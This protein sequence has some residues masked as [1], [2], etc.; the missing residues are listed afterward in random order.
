MDYVKGFSG[1]TLQRVSPGL[2]E[3]TLP[4]FMLPPIF[5]PPQEAVAEYPLSH[6]QRALWFLQRMAPES[7]A[8]N[9]VHAVRVRM[10]LDIPALRRAFQKLVDRHPVLRTTF[11][12]PHGEPV[13]RVHE[14]MEVS[15][16]VEDASTWS[17]EYLNA[18]LAEEVYRP[19]DLERGPLMRV[20]LFTRSPQDHILLLAMHHIVTDMWSMALIMYET[21]LLYQ[22]EITGV[23][24]PLKPLRFQYTDYVQWQEEMLAGPEG[25][26]LW[27]F[28]RKQLAG[29]LPVLNLPTDR[30]RPPIQTERGALQS[31]RLG[32]ELTQALKSLAKAHGATLYMTLLAAFQV[33]LHRYTGQED[34]LVGSPK[35]G[36]NRRV[37]RLVGYFINPVVLRADLSG[38]PTFSTFLKQVRQ[39]VLDAFEHDAYPFPLLVER[40]QPERDPSRPPI[41]QVVFA[42]QKTTRLVDGQGM[43]S[44]VLGLG[45]SKLELGGTPLEVVSL[46]QRVTPFDLTLLVT[47]AGRELGAAIEYNV[48]LFD[49]ATIRRMLGH[50]RT[51]LEGIVADPEQRVSDLPLLTEDERRQVLVEWNAT[52]ADYPQD[53]C[54]HELFEAQVERT[55]D[56]TAVVFED[57]QLTYRELNRRANQLA[58]YLRRLGVGPEVLVG[59][60]MERSLEMIIGLLGILKA[61]GAYLPLDPSYP[62]ERLA[63]ML[64]DAD[65]PILLT[66]THLLDRLG[67]KHNRQSAIGNRQFIICLDADWEAIAQESE[68]NPVSEVTPDNLAYVIYTSGSTGMPKGTLLEHRGLCNLIT[69]WIQDFNVGPGS[70][71]LQFFPV[72]FDGSVA[73]IFS[74]L[75]SGATLCVPRLETVVSMPDLHRLMQEQAVT[76]V[77]MTPSVLA[78]LPADGLPALENVLSGGESCTEKIAARWLSGRNFLNVYGPTEATVIASWYREG[79]SSWETA[80]VPIG[81]PI[82]NTRI[83][84]LDHHLQPV[85]VGVPGELYIGG[86][87]LARGYLN[88][89]E[90]TAERFIPDPFSGEPGAR[91]YKTGDLARYLPDGNIEFLGRTDHQVK[92][93]G[94]RVELGEIEAVLREH[95]A[96][97]EVVVVAREDVPGD[98]RLVAYVVPAQKPAPTTSEL[99][100]FLKERLPKYMIPSA[101]MVLDALPLTPN[102]KLDRRALP[103]PARVRPELERAFVAPRTPV[104]EELANIWAQLLGVER[105]GIYDNFFELGGHSLL[106]TQLLSRVRETFQV[107]VP[108]HS[109]FEAATVADLAV[110]IAQ[111]L[112]EQEDDA[113]M[114]Q[115]LAELEQLSED[116]VQ[117]M[118][119]IEMLGQ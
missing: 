40:L 100:R 59:I 42:W 54:A 84:L 90:L 47:E 61:G 80:T 57:G 58:H 9:V 101:F 51:L 5:T 28:W 68:D 50:L 30:P 76:H 46:E 23:P 74:T 114:A 65:V 106:V 24:A 10:E 43:A 7:V 56:A 12:A 11:A 22:E 66:Q 44:F 112:A 60:Y 19:F 71:M 111:H 4:T 14:H 35:A 113:Q 48:D 93:R 99:R 108:P 18:R 92:V 31:L 78:V 70:R 107:E 64:E 116:E 38:N 62:P 3:L 88:R 6:G 34:I 86:V 94:F 72:S 104:E 115:L 20:K 75:L 45:G 98:K 117:E 36:R 21:N 97:R 119:D 39:T 118:L 81:R 89:P 77:L 8:H 53:R 96:L 13:Q 1:S 103:P 27:E 2:A 25:E 15:F 41:F 52:A 110:V 17:E 32:T 49:A 85:P 79:E 37:A 29:E 33:L 109:F 69:A 67:V 63:F 55:P 105:V 16:Q 102:G 91:L 26:R 83:Y 82:A 87:N 95:P 73:E